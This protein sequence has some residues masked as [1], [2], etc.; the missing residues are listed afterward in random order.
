MGR[1]PLK[2]GLA[3]RCALGLSL[4]VGGL[5]FQVAGLVW[6]HLREREDHGSQ[7]SPHTW[8]GAVLRG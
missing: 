7:H 3:P 2:G 8:P 5:L 6:Q 1:Y 4:C